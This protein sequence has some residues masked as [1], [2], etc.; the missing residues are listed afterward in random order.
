[1][2]NEAAIV[3]FIGGL[4]ILWVVIVVFGVWYELKFHNPRK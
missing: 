4:T 3:A 2:S 1:M